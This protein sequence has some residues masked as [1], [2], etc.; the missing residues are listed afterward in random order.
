M[1]SILGG[2]PPGDKRD[3]SAVVVFYEVEAHDSD[4]RRK[5]DGFQQKNTG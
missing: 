4:S 1:V 3:S 5:S 2:L